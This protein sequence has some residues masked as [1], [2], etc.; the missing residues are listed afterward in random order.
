[1][2]EN[3]RIYLRIR[4]SKADET[5]TTNSANSSS[6]TCLMVD[7]QSPQQCVTLFNGP[8]AEIFTYDCVGGPE[9]EQEEIF[10]SVAKPVT[11]YCLQGYNGTIFAYGQTGSGKTFTMQGPIREGGLIDYGQRG[12]IPRTFEYLFECIRAEEEEAVGVDSREFLCKCSYVEIYNE[13]IFDLLD[14]S[15]GNGASSSCSL[16]EDIKRGVYIEGAREEVIN[17]PAEAY[18][19]YERGSLNRHVAET[20]MNRESSRSHS[21][22]TLFI[23][24]KQRVG[25]IM[26]V[27]ESRFNLVDLAGSERQQA[28]GTTGARLKEAGNINKSLLALSN[29]INGLVDISNGRVRHVQYRDSKL[30]FLLRDSL[31]G[32]AKTVII[33]NVSPSSLFYNETMSTLKFAQRAKMIKNKAVVNK[34]I[35]GNVLQLQAEIQRLQ[36]ELYLARHDDFSGPS[37]MDIDEVNKKPRL[38]SDYSPPIKSKGP[39]H[40]ELDPA[41]AYL[42]LTMALERQAESSDEIESFKSRIHLLEELIKRKD[43]QLQSQKMIIKFRDN[44]LKSLSHGQNDND[45]IS[46]LKNEVN[47]LRKI[48]EHHPEVTRFA[49]ENLQLREKLYKYEGIEGKINEFEAVISRHQQ[50]EQLLTNRL[51][52]LEKAKGEFEEERADSDYQNS[53]SSESVNMQCIEQSNRSNSDQL[54]LEESQEQV[55]L[56]EKDLEIEKEN[57]MELSD[58]V[59]S[60]SEKITEK[61]TLISEMNSEKLRISEDLNNLLR[62][63]DIRI[64]ERDDRI[65]EQ[66]GALMACNERIREQDRTIERIREQDNAVNELNERIREQDKTMNELNGR[67]KEQDRTITESTELIRELESKLES[68]TDLLQAHNE[69]IS[70]ERKSLSEMMKEREELQRD[71]E[72][73][74]RQLERERV[75][76]RMFSQDL[77]QAQK[78]LSI[79]IGEMSSESEKLKE[80]TLSKIKAAQAEKNLLQQELEVTRQILAEYKTRSDTLSSS[81]NSAAEQAGK[82]IVDLETEI[83]SLKEDIAKLSTLAS[84]STSLSDRNKILQAE[85]G[86]L[87]GKIGKLEFLLRSAQSDN[88]ELMSQ[89]TQLQK[90]LETSLSKAGAGS[91]GSSSSSSS[92]NHSNHSS[93]ASEL[94]AQMDAANHTISSLNR[95]LSQLEFDLTALRDENDKLTQ[96]QNVKQKLQ[97]HLKIKQE[98]NELQ[99]E[100]A[101]LKDELM[102][103][104]SKHEAV[105][106]VLTEIARSN[107]LNLTAGSKTEIEKVVNLINKIKSLTL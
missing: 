106:N 94:Q 63:N 83:A 88:D 82:R 52:V 46:D 99:D 17:S 66:E 85:N 67:I 38:I 12:L 33:A 24:S 2:A 15:A 81:N 14:V 36:H 48:I 30:T 7:P 41:E 28:T 50:Y 53:S 87:H 72:K 39:L 60:L 84:T 64:K 68:Q 45:E 55:K 44:S 27:R 6:S 97:Y 11:E 65:T 26:D 10:E 40:N 58:L 91:V 18:E 31:G 96:H 103:I 62:E 102:A 32:N 71:L 59:D 4:P 101:K 74:Q 79:R 29:V 89:V 37:A 43:S 9:T 98:N 35:Q 105:V 25:E 95:Q 49:Y 100:L 21:V 80:E 92:N 22:F 69:V 70:S 56:L 20:S 78:E 13:T 23:Q 61:E 104:R 107:Q 34:D 90:H 75:N 77:E 3:V 1:M 76:S 51:L 93:Q 73:S 8:K 5:R 47:E 86:Q 19:V 54:K 57:R 16:R 42:M